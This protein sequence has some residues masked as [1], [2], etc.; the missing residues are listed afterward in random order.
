M[1]AVVFQIDG[2]RVRGGEACKSRGERHTETRE[3]GLRSLPRP[4]PAGGGREGESGER[5][6]GQGGRQTETASPPLR[7]APPLEKGLAW[8]PQPSQGLR[9]GIRGAPTAQGPVIAPSSHLPGRRPS[10]GTLPR[11]GL[12]AR[13]LPS[14]QVTGVARA[15][16]RA[17]GLNINTRP[18]RGRRPR[19]LLPPPRG[20]LYGN[21]IC[22]CM[23]MTIFVLKRRL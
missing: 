17:I 10:S 23:L 14:S 21:R 5:A 22:I 11:R 18:A 9:P 2:D 6:G 16:C 7:F 19:S 15:L 13:A 20:L 1:L 4:P 8:C 3:G 12:G